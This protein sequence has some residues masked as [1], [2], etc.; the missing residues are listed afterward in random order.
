ML[1]TFKLASKVALLKNL[2]FNTGDVRD[3]EFDSWIRK[4]LWRTARQPTSVFLSEESHGQR[5]LVGPQGCTE[6]DPTEE[7]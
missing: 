4:I 7:T 5:S 2:P 6:L 1:Q 3:G